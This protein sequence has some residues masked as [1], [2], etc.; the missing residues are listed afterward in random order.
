MH[1]TAKFAVGCWVVVTAFW[2]VAAFSVKKTA[3]RQ[4]L[5]NRLLH[6]LLI[7]VAAI[8][9]NGTARI[10]NWNRPILPHT[11]ARGIVADLLTFVGLLIAIWARVTL[12]GNWS[13]RVTL[14]QEHELIQ[15]GPY[16]LVRHPIYSGLLLMIFGT[17]IL[18]GQV[19]GF[20]ALLICFGGFWVKL[21]QEEA[22]LTKHLPGYSEYVRRTKALVPFIL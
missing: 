20:I 18:A 17:A 14:K 19:G 16:R 7:V 21:R 15:R 6:L 12:G 10:I 4:P 9:L 5:R 3:T 13:A 1:A 8:L 2:I 11:L 22:L